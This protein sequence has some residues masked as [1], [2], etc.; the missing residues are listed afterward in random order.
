MAPRLYAQAVEQLVKAQKLNISK[1]DSKASNKAIIKTIELFERTIAS[2][3]KAAAS[4]TSVIAARQDAVGAQAIEYAEDEWIEASKAL[5]L[6]TNR[7]AKNKDIKPENRER[8]EGLFR[9]AELIA[10]KNNYLNETRNRIVIATENKAGKYAPTLLY[11]ARTALQQAEEALTENRYDTD[12]PRLLARQAKIDAGHANRIAQEAAAIRKGEQTYEYLS[13]NSEQA[14]H[15]IAESLDL[16][17]A[18]DEGAQSATP[19]Y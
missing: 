16:S 14:L 8:A 11:R 15:E 2:A 13:L 9:Q 6:L 17:I 19:G 10:I 7:I 4:L 18:L 12:K 5:E 1:P 3:E